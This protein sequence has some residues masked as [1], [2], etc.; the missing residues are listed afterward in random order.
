MKLNFRKWFT[1]YKQNYVSLETRLS[2]INK[3][4]TFAI[5]TFSQFIYDNNLTGCITA[6]PIG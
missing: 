4:Q 3:N 1:L 6:H 5:F 2:K